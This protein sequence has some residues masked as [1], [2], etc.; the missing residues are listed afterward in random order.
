MN[1]NLK[2]AFKIAHYRDMYT[3][4]VCRV[5]VR[6]HQANWRRRRRLKEQTAGPEA[7]ERRL[8]SSRHHCDVETVSIFRK[9]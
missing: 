5:V 7:C 2:E 3:Q 8:R 4:L 1:Y 9:D 6:N